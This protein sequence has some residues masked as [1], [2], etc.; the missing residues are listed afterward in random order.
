MRGLASLRLVVVT[1][2]QQL[3]AA[4]TQMW[5]FGAC[6]GCMAKPLTI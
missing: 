6:S 5:Y 2:R 3:V 4:A 1:Y